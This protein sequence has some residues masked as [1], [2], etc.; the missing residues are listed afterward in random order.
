[1]NK[2][3]FLILSNIKLEEIAKIEKEIISLEEKKLKKVSEPNVKEK[4]FIHLQRELN[5]RLDKLR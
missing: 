3:S 5:F 1:M 2:I 4:D